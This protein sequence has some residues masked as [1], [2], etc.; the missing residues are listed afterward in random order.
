VRRRA[1]VL[2]VGEFGC[3]NYGN[4]AS[5]LSVMRALNAADPDL[6]IVVL[7]RD[8]ARVL[9]APAFQE[10][11]FQAMDLAYRPIPG[12]LGQMVGRLTDPIRYLRH[13]SGARAVLVPGM[14]V[15]EGELGE[16]PFG[17]P[18][19][20]FVTAVLCC[21]A[22]APLAFVAVGASPLRNPVSLK[23]A[24][25]TA[26][27]VSY[28]S[29]RDSYSRACARDANLGRP[30]DR[31]TADVALSLPIPS[32]SH[33][34]VTGVGIGVM[35]FYGRHPEHAAVTPE[36]AHETYVTKMVAL[37]RGIGGLGR[38]IVLFAGDDSDVP[39]A[40]AIADRLAFEPGMEVE[41]SAESD[42]VG[43]ASAM[44]GL[45]LIIAAR[46]HN[47]VAAVAAGRPLI[48][49][50]Y[51]EKSSLLALRAGMTGRAP[52][53]DSWDVDELVAHA[54]GLLDRADVI[55][56]RVSQTGRELLEQSTQEL[57]EVA[58]LVVKS[59]SRKDWSR[60]GGEEEHRCA[61]APS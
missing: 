15:I 45:E 9:S 28:R 31:V 13:I 36:R 25:P 18:Y 14:G 55:A 4:D 60:L 22:R 43:I 47:L 26:R 56:E 53:L 20:L 23:M 3:G 17:V 19:L 6:R 7:A 37:C 58:G 38:R 54:A 39:V 34:A 11:D 24:V 10:L 46:Y 1:K 44:R 5:L 29:F 12:R 51:A 57:S 33:L 49:M 2:L 21:L 40:R 32:A 52:D 61:P 16:H 41:V 48:A 27:L 50:T 30:R 8:A 35:N 59:R 42:Y